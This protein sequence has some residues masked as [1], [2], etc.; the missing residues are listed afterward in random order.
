MVYNERPG[1]R[2]QRRHDGDGEEC[3]LEDPVAPAAAA[4]AEFVFVA[5]IIAE[6]GCVPV[7]ACKR[8][9]FRE[10]Q[11]RDEFSNNLML[12]AIYDIART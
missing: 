2:D 6:L 5:V 7:P 12:T 10:K 9:A 11:F 3:Y 8:R 4:A 1:E